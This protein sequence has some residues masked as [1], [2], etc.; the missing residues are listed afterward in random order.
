MDTNLIKKARC[1]DIIEYLNRTG[2]L[3]IKEGNQYRVKSLSGLVVCGNKWY[4]HTL[5]KGGNTLDY[6]IEVEGICFKQA[7]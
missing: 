4:S 2:N 7:A 1:V 6:L 3:L 5:R